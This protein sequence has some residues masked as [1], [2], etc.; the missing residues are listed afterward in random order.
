MGW[1]DV[2]RVA[3][4]AVLWVIAGS[5]LWIAVA[6]WRLVSWLPELVRALRVLATQAEDQHLPP[7]PVR[8]FPEWPPQIPRGR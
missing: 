4:W 6:L 3:A 5:L 2:A 8:E 1:E 7:R